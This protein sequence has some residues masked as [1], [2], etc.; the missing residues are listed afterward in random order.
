MWMN[1][2]FHCVNYVHAAVIS[3]N[4]YSVKRI[5]KILSFFLSFLL[6]IRPTQNREKV[7]IWR[8]GRPK[9]PP[10]TPPQLTIR[11]P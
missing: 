5:N 10:P 6:Q 4:V 3:L 9:P 8:A 11:P 1:Q 7:T 2:L